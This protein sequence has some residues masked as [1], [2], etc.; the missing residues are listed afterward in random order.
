METKTTLVA[1]WDS[2]DEEWTDEEVVLGKGTMVAQQVQI[3]KH[4]GNEYGDPWETTHL[5]C[6]MIGDGPVLMG[7]PKSVSCPIQGRVIVT[8]QRNG[9]HRGVM[10]WASE[11]GKS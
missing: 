6:E 1:I 9:K 4:F 10:V 8:Q 5:S 11:Q 2:I 3:E 7:Y